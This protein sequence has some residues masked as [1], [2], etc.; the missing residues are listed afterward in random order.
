VTVVLADLVL[1][2]HVC[3]AAFVLGGLFLLP[4]GWQLD[5]RWVR[6][7][8]FRLP[9]VIC[10]ALVAVEAL[11]GLTC[12]LTWLENML[13]AASAAPGDERSF[14]GHFLYWLLYYDAPAWVFVVTYTALALTVGLLY[15][16]LPPLLKPNG[17]R[18]S[19][20]LPCHVSP[21]PW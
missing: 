5:W 18:P 19:N 14:V 21:P 11:I 16:Y 15:Y 17:P 6:A 3:Y 7:R 9:H 20:A 2:L 8:A 12:P 4:L 10:T 1:F 13:R